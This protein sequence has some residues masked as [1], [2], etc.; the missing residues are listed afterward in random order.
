MLILNL[1]PHILRLE[2]VY[3]SVCVC[4]FYRPVFYETNCVITILN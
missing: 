1:M 4:V 2:K 3:V